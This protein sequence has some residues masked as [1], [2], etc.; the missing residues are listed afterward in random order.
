[1]RTRPLGPGV[2]GLYYDPL[3]HDRKA[4]GATTAGAAAR[5]HPAEPL[6]GAWLRFTVACARAGARLMA[7]RAAEADRL[8]TQTLERLDPTR[9]LESGERPRRYY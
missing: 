1:M 2:G 4:A 3:L 9:G 6:R 8:I 7:A 5:S